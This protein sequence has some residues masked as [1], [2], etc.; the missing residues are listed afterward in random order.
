V[1]K[2]K[3]N[4]G[5]SG[6]QVQARLLCGVVCRVLCVCVPCAGVCAVAVCVPGVCGGCGVVWVCEPWWH[7]NV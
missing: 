5:Q 7:R 2:A 3:V 6:G 4:C 1:G